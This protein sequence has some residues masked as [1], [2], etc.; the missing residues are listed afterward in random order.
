MRR[1]VILIVT[2]HIMLFVAQLIPYPKVYSYQTTFERHTLGFPY[3]ISSEKILDML[4]SLY[5]NLG[6]LSQGYT[7]PIEENVTQ[8]LYNTLNQISDEN[9]KS[10]LADIANSYALNGS[11]DRETLLNAVE[12]ATKSNASL[13]DL[14]QFLNAVNSLAQAEGYKD[15]VTASEDTIAKILE[16]LANINWLQQKSNSASQVPQKIVEVL[17]RIPQAIESMPSLGVASPQMLAPSMQ[18]PSMS[19]SIDRGTII[20]ILGI[21]LAIVIIAVLRGAIAS[22]IRKAHGWRGFA[23]AGGWHTKTFA[24][25]LR[26]AIENYWRAVKFVE[27]VYMVRKEDSMTHR[28]YLATVSGKLKDLGTAFEKITMMYEAARYAHDP[29]SDVDEESERYLRILI[30]GKK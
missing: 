16:K 5:K 26:K 23:G 1:I 17:P 12:M 4:K 24:Q 18:L 3:N 2:L 19:L 6:N 8:N 25:P 7:A 15:I 27:S 13:S 29:R 10:T 9:L 20:L 22:L 14:L 21:T 28:E 11:I 30:G